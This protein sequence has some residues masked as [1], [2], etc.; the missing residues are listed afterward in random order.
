MCIQAGRTA[1]PLK[2]TTN[3]F[4]KMGE[5][6]EFTKLIKLMVQ[7]ICHS[8]CKPGVAGSIPGFSSPSDGTINRGPVSILP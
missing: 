2:A 6:T 7:W 8:P 3:L 4:Y 5:L 1:D